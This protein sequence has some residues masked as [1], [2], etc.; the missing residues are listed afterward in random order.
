MVGGKG[1]AQGAGVVGLGGFVPHVLHPGI[2]LFVNLPGL[3]GDLVHLVFL[4]VE[5]NLAFVEDG[6]EVLVEFGVQDGADVFQGE[7]LFHCGLADAVPGDIPLPD[8]HDALSMVNQVM[9]LTL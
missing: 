6:A 4:G 2:T 3:L 1:L 7:A 9:Y 5:L 8:V